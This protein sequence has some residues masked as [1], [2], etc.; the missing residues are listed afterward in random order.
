MFT[1]RLETLT[2]R[3]NLVTTKLTTEQAKDTPNEQVVTRLTNRLSRIQSRIDVI[4]GE[5]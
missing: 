5:G 1:K 4:N 2:K 3:F